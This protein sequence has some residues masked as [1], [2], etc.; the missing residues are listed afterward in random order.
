MEAAGE[1]IVRDGPAFY[2]ADKLATDSQVAHAERL[3]LVRREGPHWF[4]RWG[5][6]L[7][8]VVR[9][10]LGQ[11]RVNRVRAALAPAPVDPVAPGN[12]EERLQAEVDKYEKQ[13]ALQRSLRWSTRRKWQ[14]FALSALLFLGIG[15]LWIS[16]TFLP[17]LLAVIA[18]HEGG[19]FL[20]M[21]FLRFGNLSVFFVPGLGGLASGEKPTAGPWE[22][23]LV[24]LAGPVPGIL[25]ASAGLAGMVTGTFVPSPWFIEF[26]IACLIINYLN[27][28]PVSPLDGGRIVETLLFARLP[29]A[30]F[31]FAVL[32][33]LV[34]L[35]A[36]ARLD[37]V[38][39]LVVGA[40]VGLSLPHQWRVMRVDR[41][42]ERK[43][44]ETITERAAME[45]IFGALQ[46]PA[47]ARWDALARQSIATSLMPEL[48]GRQARFFESVC[49]MAVYLLC[50]FG[51]LVLALQVSGGWQTAALL[52]GMRQSYVADDIDRG[53]S[54][55]APPA[56]RDWY[57]EAE[58]VASV[59]PAQRLHVLLRAAEQ[60]HDE[61]EEER[62]R[63]YLQAAWT[64]AEKRPSGDVERAEA[65]FQLSAI[66]DG[67]SAQTRLRQVVQEQE[68]TTDRRALLLLARVKE[69]LALGAATAGDEVAQ[70]EQAVA[71]RKS[72]ESDAQGMQSAQSAL[73]RAYD[74][75]GQAAQAEAVLRRIVDAHVIPSPADRS[76]DALRTRVQRTEA[77]INLAWY[78]ISLHRPGEAVQL[79]QH[80]TARLPAKVSISWQHAN[81]RLHEA[82]SWAHL[83]QRDQAA[84]RGAWSTYE[85][86]RR[87]GAWAGRPDGPFLLHEIDRLIVAQAL[88]D[89]AMKA[90]AEA[91]IKVSDT[92]QARRQLRF[93]LCESS[94]SGSFEMPKPAARTEVARSV[95]F[96]GGS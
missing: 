40:L 4:L 53:P 78:L 29:A 49:G 58:N 34:L 90:K 26:L 95:G 96:C 8:Y 77:E 54:R 66:E 68:G 43:A 19:H 12:L 55:E 17:I 46:R 85:T 38:V 83:V 72:A 63:R 16:W 36:G 1:A 80:A 32:G 50:L 87:E 81:Q 20:A 75:N 37:D 71:H 89:E 22:K 76:G 67:E 25:L 64:E 73:A 42:I 86:S 48:Q 88:N 11:R 27:L 6:A 47:F 3:G 65:L 70:L 21:K 41:S 92:P 24:Y 18:L 93:Q 74:R 84:L 44:G 51:P 91:A 31:G 28:L 82:L 5:A 7:R 30:R 23:L 59:A 13:L 14:M 15:S 61:Y 39:L 2:A 9:W 60:A 45:R 79:L 35:G 52:F 57:P 33:V 62:R 10:N 56:R 69:N 94:W